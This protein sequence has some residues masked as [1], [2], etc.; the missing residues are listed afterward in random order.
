MNLK[1]KNIS[2]DIS[3]TRRGCTDRQTKHY[4]F[5]HGC[6]LAQRYET[7]PR[8]YLAGKQSVYSIN[9]DLYHLNPQT[10]LELSNMQDQRF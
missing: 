3:F 9:T 5:G 4:A 10:D 6:G 1:K 2:L 8:S 7:V